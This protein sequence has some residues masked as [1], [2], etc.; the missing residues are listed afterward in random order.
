M[1]V[2]VVG[3]RKLRVYRVEKE[4]TLPK[5]LMERGD[6]REGLIYVGEVYM[7]Y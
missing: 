7:V 2:E 4:E 1:V 3:Y 5:R 6:T